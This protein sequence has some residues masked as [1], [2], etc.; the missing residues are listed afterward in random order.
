MENQRRICMGLVIIFT[1]VTLL[2]VFAT[3]K[4]SWKKLLSR[5]AVAIATV[6]SF[7]MVYN[8]D[9]YYNGVSTSSLIR[10][11]F[12]LIEISHKK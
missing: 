12:I 9:F 5:A 10:L 2:A 4:P 7:R 6:Y 1:L 3:L 11:T 8:H